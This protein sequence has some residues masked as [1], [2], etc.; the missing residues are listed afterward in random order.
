M[1][2]GEYIQAFDD[3]SDAIFRHAFFKLSDRERAVELMQETFTK[4][5]EYL[6]QGRKIINI[7]AFLYKVLNNLVIDEYRK[8]RKTVSLEM[9][10]EEGFEIPSEEKLPLQDKLDFELALRHFSKLE[11]P[12]REVLVMRYVDNLEPKSIAEILGDSENAVSVRL[13]RGINK[14]Q[15]LMHTHHE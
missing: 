5:W 13:H 3:Y 11:E 2:Q 15:E 6:E 14:L 9:L 4:T 1:H 10:V 8:D 7:R 12:Y